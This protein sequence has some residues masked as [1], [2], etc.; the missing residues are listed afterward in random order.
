[1]PR[2][3]AVLQSDHPYNISAR[4]INRD[5]F[6]LPMDQVWEIFNEELYMTN[7]LYDL[8]IHSFVLMGNHFHMIATTPKANISKCMS[9][10]MKNSSFRLTRAGNRINQTFGGRHFKTM[11]IKANHYLNAYKY[12]YRN[13]VEAGVC[14]LAE[15]YQYSTL[16][17]LLGIT[18]LQIPVCD[19]VTLF[20]D[21][22]GTLRWLNQG[23]PSEKVEAVRYALKRPFFKSKVC[24]KTRKP[25]IGDFELI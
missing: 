17:G 9:Y 4:C 8:K 5:W 15:E 10:F 25:L 3:L 23:V 16:S 19:D 2:H 13:P 6:K 20:S 11:L 7:M 22:E 18:R 1:M 14:R 12:N 21:V 24:R